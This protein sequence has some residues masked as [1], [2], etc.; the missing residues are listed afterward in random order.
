MNGW[1]GGP[2]LQAV[3]LNGTVDDWIRAFV[4]DDRLRS[5]ATPRF[6]A[7]PHDG[8]EP[9][10]DLPGGRAKDRFGRGADICAR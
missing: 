6:A 2:T 5:A 3:T 9:G 4:A 7:L 1:L 10:A 8:F